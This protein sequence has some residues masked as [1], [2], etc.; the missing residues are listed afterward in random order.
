MQASAPPISVTKVCDVPHHT[1]YHGLVAEAA[2]TTVARMFLGITDAR[3][4]EVGEVD[5]RDTFSRTQRFLMVPSAQGVCPLLPQGSSVPTVMVTM[6]AQL[7]SSVA[8][9]LDLDAGRQIIVEGH[10]HPESYETSRLTMSV[11][12]TFANWPGADFMVRWGCQ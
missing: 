11:H 8:I 7:P 12:R 10:V 9:T 5:D 1:V 4:Y 3:L 2:V 6:I